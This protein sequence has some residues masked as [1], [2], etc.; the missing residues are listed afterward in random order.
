MAPTSL[1]SCLPK[2]Y[3]V[4]GIVRRSS[5]VNRTRIDHLRRDPH[6]PTTRLFLHYGD[7]ADSG[8]LTEIIY[9]IKPDEIYNLA[10][11]SHVRISFDLSEYTGD[12]TGLGTTRLLEA[13]RRSGIQTKFYQASSSEMFGNAPAPQSENTPLQPRSPYAVAKVYAYWMVR[14]YREGYNLFACNGILFNHESPRRGENFVTRKITQSIA[15]ILSKKANKLYLGNLEAKRDWGYAPEYVEAM[16]LMLQQETPDDFVI[17]TGETHSVDE[18][19]AEAFGYVN[20]DRH[21]YIEI[22]PRFFRPTEVPELRADTGK[23]KRSSIGFQRSL[24]TTLSR[25]WSTPISRCS[26]SIRRA[27]GKRSPLKR[28]SNGCRK[29]P[30]PDKMSDKI[31]VLVTGATGFVGR[32]LIQ[33]LEGE[34]PSA[35]EIFGTAYPDIPPPS[36]NRH[37]FLDLRS[38]KDVIKLMGEIRPDWVFHLAAVSNVR[39]SW[40]M[41]GETIE[42]NVSGTHNL[43]EAVRQTVPSARVLFI[44]SSDVYCF[45]PAPAEALREEA[46]LEAISPYAFSKVAGEML[47]G[48]YGKL[49]NI[50]IVI[51][52]P[53]PHTGPG[54]TE[55]FVCSDWAR[56]IVQIERGDIPGILRVGNIDVRR[57]FCDVRD[58]VKA[59]ILLL[60]KGR[61]GEAYNICSGKALMLREVL[62]FLISESAG[63]TTISVEVDAAKLRKNDVHSLLGSNQKILEE[64]RWSPK[65]PIDNTLRDLLAFWRHGLNRGRKG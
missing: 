21:K 38:E 25:S 11:Q 16:W 34:G 19:I 52:R 18:F 59:Y 27:R 23:A 56:Q 20:L 58:V 10:S 15:Q 62:D 47:C 48:F 3:E 6:L 9:N 7:L 32:H 17:G 14:N 55:D 13:V 43:L 39:R 22:E 46:P 31:R 8:Q 63:N 64:T 50:D 60:K 37:F 44:S 29:R 12:I 5:S 42:T 41:R 33:A 51:A 45:G 65:I 54:Q 49:E 57:D 4:H 2:G 36:D 28:A 40:Q 26:E 61:R 53:F 1:N 30:V 24:S 35:F